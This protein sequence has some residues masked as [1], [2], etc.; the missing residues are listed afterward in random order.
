[1]SF[2]SLQSTGLA[3]S[4]RRDHDAYGRPVHVARQPSAYWVFGGFRMSYED[5]TRTEE[6]WDCDYDF[7]GLPATVFPTV[8]ACE[9]AIV[10]LCQPLSVAA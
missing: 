7:D 4:H 5:W 1:M 9:H 10:A 3:P 2:Q 6:G 8:E